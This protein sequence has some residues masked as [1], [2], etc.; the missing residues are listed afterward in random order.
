M[1]QGRS[2]MTDTSTTTGSDISRRKVA[3]AALWSVPVVSLAMAAPAYAI[4]P[5][6]C[7]TMTWTSGT[8]SGRDAGYTTATYGGSITAGGSTESVTVRSTM[9]SGS[10][11]ATEYGTAF[12]SSKGGTNLNFVTYA[13]G[14]QRG[15]GF[16][17]DTSQSKQFVVQSGTTQSVLVLNQGTTTTRASQTLTFSFGGGQIPKSV[18]M[19][20]Y[21]ITQV[22]SNP[23]AGAGRYTDQVIFSGGTVS[24]GTQGGSPTVSVSGNTLTGTNQSTS[25]GNYIPVT[26]TGLTG[27]SLT[28]EYRNAST[29]INSSGATGSIVNNVQYIAIGD[30]R[31]CY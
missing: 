27:S 16:N 18:S 29:D 20:I 31:V 12:R 8:V 5:G 26:V 9:N 23:T 10:A 22:P 21:D 30:V 14:A 15:V 11:A 13:A 6:Q 19:N 25:T 24:T 1:K 17:T 4:S 3:A 7:A 2:R 28:L